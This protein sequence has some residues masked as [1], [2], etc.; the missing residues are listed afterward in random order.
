MPELSGQVFKAIHQE[1][2]VAYWNLAVHIHPIANG[3]SLWLTGFQS[4]I[5]RQ[6]QQSFYFPRHLLTGRAAHVRR[7]YPLLH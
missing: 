7:V 2:F 5:A 3:P 6:I 4:K 1:L